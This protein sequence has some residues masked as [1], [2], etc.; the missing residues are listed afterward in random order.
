MVLRRWVA[1]IQK[2][3]LHTQNNDTQTDLQQV[4]SLLDDAEKEFTEARRIAPYEEHA[5]ISH[6]QL[7]TKAVDFG[8]QKSGK[9][10]ITDFLS[11]PDSLPYQ[12]MVERAE[13]ILE[14]VKRLRAGREPGS[15]VQSCETALSEFYGDYELVLQRWNS[16]LDRRDI[17]APPVRRRLV[18]A[19]LA[20][21]N[22]SWDEISHAALRR[23]ADLMQDNILDEPDNEG[24]IRLWFNAERRLPSADIDSAIE[25]LGNWHSRS[26]SLDAAYYL[27]VLHSLNAIDGSDYAKVQ[28]ERFIK[29]CK[30]R[31]RH[32]PHGTFSF[33]WFGKGT[34]MAR[35]IHF[36][37]LGKFDENK[38]FYE[39]DSYLV[40]VLGK[41]A[42]VDRPEAG[43]LE[44]RCGLRVFF[45]PRPSRRS[46]AVTIV[47]GDVNKDVEF[48]LG[49]SY[50]GPRA[51][52]VGFKQ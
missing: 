30:M 51:W 21:S 41:I 34:G 48:H 50:E 9:R 28:A 37:K 14:E 5:Y 12:E 49:F 25:R 33:D 43:W 11:S 18:R 31:A 40:K 47:S 22:R 2:K 35:L 7:L 52:G 20:R 27:Y 1:A 3:L 38:D 17:Y 13:K 6:I 23:I 10:D 45:I 26:G 32:L 15:Y 39:H 44:L 8:F 46:K 24:N 16:L 29:E 42:K 19:Y 4:F 36:P